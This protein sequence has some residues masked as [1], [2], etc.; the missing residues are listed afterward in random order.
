MRNNSKK[1]DNTSKYDVFKI[2]DAIEV[3]QFNKS[4][5]KVLYVP[6]KS[7]QVAKKMLK[8]E[9]KAGEVVIKTY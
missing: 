2:L 7:Y 6:K 9:G 1:H 5:R 3:L 8:I 4:D